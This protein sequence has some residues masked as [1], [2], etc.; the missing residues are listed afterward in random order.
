MSI[1]SSAVLVRLNIS[2]WTAN[3]L[4]RTA[5]D[6]VLAYN[7]AFKNAAH[8]R[9]NLMVG[10]RDLKDISDYSASCRLWHNH[11][12]LPWEDRGRRLL[13]TSLFLDY[14]A[15]QNL[16]MIEFNKRVLGFKSNYRQHIQVSKNHSGRLFDES[17]YPSEQ[18]LEEK[19]GWHFVVTPVPASGHFV[20]DLPAEEMKEMRA[21]CDDDVER[22]VKDAVKGAW[23]RLHTTVSEM[24]AKLVEPEDE[25]KKKRWHETFVT[26]AQELCRILTHLNVT[27]DPK[28]E[29]ARKQLENTMVGA[30]IDQIKE[31]PVVRERLKH[32][33]D[34][35]LE[36][37]DW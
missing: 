37:F 2:V 22:R 27:N 20:V 36:N 15:Q 13:P 3:K 14:K 7:N 9:K 35:I 33:V 10:T 30:D 25:S 24:S 32:K 34:S 21:S 5:T 23:N 1:S 19:F 12:T 16:R 17:D 28:L 26:N 11:M 29:E 31:S 4:D 18:E 6:Q 8:V